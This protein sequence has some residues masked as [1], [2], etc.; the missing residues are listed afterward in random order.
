[1]R[2][3]PGLTYRVATLADAGVVAD[4]HADSWR[5]H[6]RGAYA[7]SFLDGDVVADRLQ[8]W[9]ERLANPQG[10]QTVVADDGAEAVGFVHTI[11]DADPTYG[12]LLDNLHV[13]AAHQRR[14][15]GR[16]LMAASADF[17]L[18]ARPDSGLFL[19]VLEQNAN[20][21]AFYACLGGE[22]ADTKLVPPPSG[23]DGRLNGAP[24]GIR[25]VWPDPSA[26]A[27]LGVVAGG[28]VGGVGRG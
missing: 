16:Q 20:A 26:L 12:A 5:R 7:D 14:G 11:L 23:I 18:G 27:R 10:T 2:G 22:A 17:V 9:S 1:M 3:M 28:E 19:W 8:V 25:M 4:L 13:S 6:Y 21:Q 15:I 24:R